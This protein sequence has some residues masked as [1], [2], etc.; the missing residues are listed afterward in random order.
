MS[1]LRILIASGEE[2][3]REVLGSILRADGCK[4][5]AVAS[6]DEAI[7]QAAQLGPD[8]LITETIMPGQINGL[9]AAKRIV[10]ETKCKVLF[11]EAIHPGLDEYF[12]GLRRDIPDCDIL[13]TPFEK[14]ELLAIVHRRVTGWSIAERRNTEKLEYR[15]EEELAAL[16]QT[17]SAGTDRERNMSEAK[18]LQATNLLLMLILALLLWDSFLKPQ[19]K[20]ADRFRPIGADHYRVLDTKTGKL[21]LTTDILTPHYSR[22]KDVPAP[23]P[24]SLTQT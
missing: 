23:K 3:M 10:Q 2:A 21:C 8:T 1:S 22:F 19:P 7:S 5:L 12:D 17:F 14:D 6:T 18:L 15:A 13:P 16:N 11:L 24:R 4:V 9:R 20:A